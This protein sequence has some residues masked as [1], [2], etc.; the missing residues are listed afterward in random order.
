LNRIWFI[1]EKNI[2]EVPRSHGVGVYRII[3]NEIDTSESDIY[4]YLSILVC[5]VIWFD[6]E[7]LLNFFKD[8]DGVSGSFTHSCRSFVTDN[9]LDCIYDRIGFSD[10]ATI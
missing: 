4:Q 10:D 9:S 8:Y 5:N 1:I 6:T 3:D 2:L 7:I